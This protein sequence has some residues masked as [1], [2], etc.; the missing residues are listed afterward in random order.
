M[1]NVKAIGDR[2]RF[3][4]CFVHRS[5][6]QVRHS[7]ADVLSSDHVVLSKLLWG[8]Q[9]EARIVGPAGWQRN[10]ETHKVT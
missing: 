3:W 10:D 8:D 7:S 2:G 4:A 1:W 9:A 6:G 5:L